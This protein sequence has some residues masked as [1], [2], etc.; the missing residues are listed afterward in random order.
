MSAVL[1]GSRH[2]APS[3]TKPT[4]SRQTIPKQVYDSSVKGYVCVI[5]GAKLQLPI[6]HSKAGVYDP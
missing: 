5:K 6:G 1:Q 2:L 4:K 3:K